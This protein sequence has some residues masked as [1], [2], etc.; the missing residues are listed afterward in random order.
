MGRTNLGLKQCMLIVKYLVFC[1]YMKV[2]KEE[3]RQESQK[4][5]YLLMCIPLEQRHKF[6]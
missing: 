2:D 1:L 4:K 3:R 5:V 6:Q